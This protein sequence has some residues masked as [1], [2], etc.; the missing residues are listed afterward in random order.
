MLTDSPT[1]PLRQIT[2]AVDGAGAPNKQLN[3]TGRWDVY[4]PNEGDVGE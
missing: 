1:D 2:P 4:T 3:T